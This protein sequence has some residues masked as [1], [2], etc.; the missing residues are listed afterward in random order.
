MVRAFKEKGNDILWLNPYKIRR[1][2]KNNT[3][4][5]I[6]NKIDKIN[7]DFVFITSKDIPL[8]VLREIK[9]KSITSFIYYEDMSPQLSND[10]LRLYF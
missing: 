9:A 1:L 3:N 4:T 8:P 6:L 7:P 2:K 10:I 5:F